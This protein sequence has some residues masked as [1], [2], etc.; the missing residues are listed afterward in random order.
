MKNSY[1]IYPILTCKVVFDKSVFTYLRNFGEKTLVPMWA[2]LIEGGEE[3]ILVDPACSLE[4]FMKYSILSAGGEEGPPIEDS[5]KERGISVSDVKTII[6]THLHMD[7]CLNAKKFPNAKIIVQEEELNF[8]KDPHPLFSQIFKNEWYEG[9][10]FETIVGDTEIIPG[11]K[12]VFTP[13]HSP[14]CQSVSVTTEQGEAVIT[15][16]CALD[17]NFSDTGDIIPGPHVD[18]FKCYD[19][20]IKVREI[21]DIIIPLHSQRLLNVERIP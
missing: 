6:T 12:A 4:E 18:P 11:I 14:G 15:G 1:V 7:H 9:L 8:A 3:P 5:L 20:M 21:A 10:N 2:W 16:F 13:G 17:D 19:S